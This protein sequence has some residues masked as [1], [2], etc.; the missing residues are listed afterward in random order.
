MGARGTSDLG[1]GNGGGGQGPPGGGSGS[2]AAV[3]NRYLGLIRTRILAH[4][5]YPP[6][7][8]ARQMEG[9]VRLRFTLNHTGSLSREVQV[10]KPSGFSVLDEQAVQCVRAAAPF[11]PF[12]PELR[13]DSLTVEVPIVYRLKDWSG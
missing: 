13:K 12:P 11:P 1:S 4:R 3:Q 9:E 2:L 5:H 10:V 7:A 6:I 8:R